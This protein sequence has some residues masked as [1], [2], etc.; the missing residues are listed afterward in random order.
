MYKRTKV[1]TLRAI[2]EIRK[3]MSEVSK[4]LDFGSVSPEARSQLLQT[5]V[6]LNARLAE[7][8]DTLI[9]ARMDEINSEI[10]NVPEGDDKARRIL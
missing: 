2:R 3:E 8:H 4:Q 10:E 9:H 7:K 5:F 1:R 6:D